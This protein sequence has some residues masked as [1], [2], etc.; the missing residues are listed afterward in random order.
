M[1]GPIDLVI[2]EEAVL[3]VYARD[4]GRIER[5]EAALGDGWPLSCALAWSDFENRVEEARCAVVDLPRITERSVPEGLLAF[6]ARFPAVPL[7]LVTRRRAANLRP[8][9]RV[10]LEEVV[11]EQCL[12]GSLAAAVESASTSGVLCRAARRVAATAGVPPVIAR[13]LKIALE[14]EPP[15][16]SV[17]AWARCL[18][19]DRR[20]LWY[21][22]QKLDE[23]RE[24]SASDVPPSP[25]ELLA[26]VQIVRAVG[27]R[28]PG[29]SWQ[30]VADTLRVDTRTLRRRAK[31]LLDRPL[32]ELEVADA[33]VRSAF[34]SRLDRL[35][36]AAGNGARTD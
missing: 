14:H 9:G 15:L 27:A 19:R 12:D 7:V 30:A 26:W 4:P 3:A 32:S 8:L 6:N 21:H 11:W 29:R 28:R 36:A 34:E 17:T 1:E 2:R 20:T 22:W 5:I 16:R 23:G 13:A 35:L 33:E 25:K 24:S 31:R 10:E 18:D